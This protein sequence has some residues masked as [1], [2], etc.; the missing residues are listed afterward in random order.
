MLPL[1][2]DIVLL[3]VVKQRLLQQG[4]AGQQPSVG[5]AIVSVFPC[6][7]RRYPGKQPVA[8]MLLHLMCMPQ[9]VAAGATS[10]RLIWLLLLLLACAG[11]QKYGRSSFLGVLLGCITTVGGTNAVTY[12]C[13]VHPHQAVVLSK[14]STPCSALPASLIRPVD[15][16]TWARMSMSV[17]HSE[18]CPHVR[19]PQLSL[20]GHTLLA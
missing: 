20:L 10:V 17:S 13:E 18:R 12:G 7:N 6:G 16:W 3:L 11:Q 8:A 4:I 9:A 2:S 5:A 19:L 14:H 1:L 15:L